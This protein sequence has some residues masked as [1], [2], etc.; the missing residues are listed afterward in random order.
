MFFSLSES[1]SGVLDMT[2]KEYSIS[3]GIPYDTVRKQFQKF[4]P[5]LEKNITK[6]G[7]ASDLNKDAVAFLDSKQK[8]KPEMILHREQMFAM[9]KENEVLEKRVEELYNKVNHL[10]EKLEKLTWQETPKKGT[11]SW[12]NRIK[13]RIFPGTS[14]ASKKA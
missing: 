1:E 3:R 5:L 2:L 7:R 6:K 11:E 14:S 13:Q 8:S 12:L 4:R 10:Q 9:R